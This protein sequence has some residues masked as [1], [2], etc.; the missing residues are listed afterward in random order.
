MD[1][2]AQD[3]GESSVGDYK[4]LHQTVITANHELSLSA[5]PGLTGGHTL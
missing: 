2:G 5:K 1:A 4:N 3:R